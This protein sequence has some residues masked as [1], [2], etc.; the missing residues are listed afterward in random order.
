MTEGRMYR[1]DTALTCIQLTQSHKS[2][3]CTTISKVSTIAI[4][5]LTGILLTFYLA[6]YSAPKK[7]SYKPILYRIFF[8]SLHTIIKMV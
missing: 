5:T 4:I 1:V 6:Q 7:K 3:H 2:Q 8:G